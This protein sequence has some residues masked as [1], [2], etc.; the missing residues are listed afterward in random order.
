LRT[1]TI[2]LIDTFTDEI[3]LKDVTVKSAAEHLGIPLKTFQNTMYGDCL[4]KGRYKPERT[5]FI[6][7]QNYLKTNSPETTRSSYEER[8][9][10]LWE[11]A[12]KPFRILSQRK[13]AA[14]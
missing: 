6:P 1:I 12:V 8:F 11:D 7:S 4:I 14:L 5:G 3:I 2:N 10:I 9:N 13:K